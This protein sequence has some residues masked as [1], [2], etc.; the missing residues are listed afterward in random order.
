MTVS[1]ST[2]FQTHPHMM[3]NVPLTSL[4]K[5][6]SLLTCFLE[7]GLHQP[8]SD[9]HRISQEHGARETTKWPS[10]TGFRDP[11]LVDLQDSAEPRPAVQRQ[12]LAERQQIGNS[13]CPSGF[14]VSNETKRT[15]LCPQ[16]RYNHLE[17]TVDDVMSKGPVERGCP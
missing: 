15:P 16:N 7:S 9:L 13:P 14:L 11:R 5:G 17:N 12:A 2:I 4:Q 1:I 10:R 6:S 3:S 8:D